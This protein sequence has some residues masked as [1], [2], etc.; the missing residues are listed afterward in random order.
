M[1]QPHDYSVYNIIPY[2]IIPYTRNDSSTQQ[3]LSYNTWQSNKHEKIAHTD[4]FKSFNSAIVDADGSFKA[5][6]ILVMVL[7]TNFTYS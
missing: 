7:S 3:S 5:S 1:R 4:Y 2:T 6:V